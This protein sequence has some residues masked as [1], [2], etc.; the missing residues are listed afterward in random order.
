[1]W[2]IAIVGHLKPGWEDAGTIADRL[3]RLFGSFAGIDPMFSRW[4][5]VG[6]RRHRSAVP[7]FI[8]IPPDPTELRSWIEEGAV[9]GSRDG[10]KQTVG[11]AIHARTPA[12]NPVRAGFWLSFLPEDWW[13]GHRVGITIFSGPGSPSVLDQP[14]N[15]EA[16]IALLRRVLL[17]TATAWECDWA[18]VRP[19]NYRPRLQLPGPIPIKYESGWMVYLGAAR[20]T[21]IVPP[22]DVAVERLADGAVLFTAATDAIF[23]GSNPNHIAAALRIQIALEPLNETE[24]E[25]PS[26]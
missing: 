13:F 11:Y 6:A 21:L 10:R 3:G 18:G 16:A 23:N 9:F 1:M 24:N 4:R 5:R 12:Q 15:Q 8:S 25:D 17:V 7:A 20:A 14:G 26:G 22:R 2:P 19:G